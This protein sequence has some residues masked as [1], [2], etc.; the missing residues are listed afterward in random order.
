[1]EHSRQAVAPGAAAA[2]AR[3]DGTR[4]G[5][6]ADSFSSSVFRRDESSDR[7]S[8]AAPVKSLKT[9][10][11]EES[12]LR[13]ARLDA[14]HRLRLIPAA[15]W[16][17]RARLADTVDASDDAAAADGE[18]TQVT[19][20][21]QQQQRTFLTEGFPPGASSAREGG[22]APAA[23]PTHR[24]GKCGLDATSAVRNKR[25]KNRATTAVAVPQRSS[26][27]HHHHDGDDDG[28]GPVT[29]SGG[30]GGNGGGYDG[31]FALPIGASA[32]FAQAASLK[33]T[34]VT[35]SVP[36]RWQSRVVALSSLRDS[37]REGATRG[38]PSMGREMAR[39]RCRAHYGRIR[40]ERSAK[41]K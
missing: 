24:R 34:A 19:A 7:H 38:S 27:G 1:M 29:A 6:E 25:Q 9:L 5:G 11:S 4:D 3:P 13:D 35:A 17:G 33:R 22:L 32:L 12:S 36:L 39:T 23:T 8:S 14:Q 18:E 10:L 15:L 20:E 40:A 37:F 21:Q 31:G 2:A 28:H 30:G 16:G 26:S 41:N